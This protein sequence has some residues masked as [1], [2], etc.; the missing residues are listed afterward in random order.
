MKTLNRIIKEIGPSP[1][2]KAVWTKKM[3]KAVVKE[4][5]TQEEEKQARILDS[6]KEKLYTFISAL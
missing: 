4:Y 3:I 5:V 1:G 6:K 2:T